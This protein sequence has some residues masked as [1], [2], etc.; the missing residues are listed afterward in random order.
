MA[1]N[2]AGD[3]MGLLVLPDGS[4]MVVRRGKGQTYIGEGTSKKQISAAEVEGWFREA[5][6]GS[7]RLSV[8]SAEACEPITKSLNMMLDLGEPPEMQPPVLGKA[9][10]YGLLFL[11]HLPNARKIMEGVLPGRDGREEVL[12]KID[13]AT[14]HVQ[15]LLSTFDFPVTQWSWHQRACAVAQLT[16]TAWSTIGKAPKA[17]N[18]DDPLCRFVTSAMRAIGHAVSPEAVSEALR[19]RR[20]LRFKRKGKASSVI[21]P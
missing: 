4:E 11:K 16:R 13:R 21:C 9:E 20:G 15:A 17:K 7:K 12:A 5:T 18:P 2:K 8:P 1:D 6:A 14:E 3:I 10:K 19:G